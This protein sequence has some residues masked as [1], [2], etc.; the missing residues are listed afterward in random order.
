MHPRRL[1]VVGVGIARF[2]IAPVVLRRAIDGDRRSV[3]AAVLA[4][5][6]LL[7]LILRLIEIRTLLPS[8]SSKSSASAKAL[9]Q[10]TPWPLLDFNTQLPLVLLRRYISEM[11]RASEGPLY[12]LL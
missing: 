9:F 7:D 8:A 11:P 10:Y 6:Q 12:G 3:G 5:R 1:G 4:A 2:E